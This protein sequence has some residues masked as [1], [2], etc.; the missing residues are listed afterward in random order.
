MAD[1]KTLYQ[2]LSF[3]NIQSYIQS[4]NVIFNSHD[5]E[6][7]DCSQL[8]KKINQAIFAHYKFEVPVFVITPIDLQSARANLPFDNID[9]AADGSKILLCFLSDFPNNT[10][11]NNPIALLTPYLKKNEHLHIIGKV[12]YLHCEDGYGRSKL[13]HS[14]IERKLKVNATSRNLKTVDKLITLAAKNIS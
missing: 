4:G 3:E 8:A 7:S 1:L 2:Q 10:I 12:L 14:N 13:T 6:V 5:N 11:S 9:V